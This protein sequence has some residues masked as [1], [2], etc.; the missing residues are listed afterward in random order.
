MLNNNHYP[1][2]AF[3]NNVEERRAHMFVDGADSNIEPKDNKS[4]TDIDPKGTIK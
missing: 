1:L 4:V 2:N 3:G